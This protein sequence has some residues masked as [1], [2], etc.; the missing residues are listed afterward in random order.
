M[1]IEFR[2]DVITH[3]PTCCL[4][5]DVQKLRLA[6]NS[7]D[8][9]A[10]ETTIECLAESI[11]RFTEVPDGLDL[12]PSVSSLVAMGCESGIIT[13]GGKD[14]DCAGGWPVSSA[15]EG[16]VCQ[17]DE[18]CAYYGRKCHPEYGDILLK[19]NFVYDGSSR[20][21]DCLIDHLDRL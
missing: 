21:A 4:I 15:M 9:D 8:W 13:S 16:G 14:I 2:N 7:G 19:E 10:V 20:Q 6:V 1:K 5:E 18:K 3:V 11:D 12:K 17:C